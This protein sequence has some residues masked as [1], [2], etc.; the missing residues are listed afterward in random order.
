VRIR[1]SGLPIL[2]RGGHFQEPISVD[3]TAA[4]SV[5]DGNLA[6]RLLGISAAFPWCSNF[7]LGRLQARGHL[8]FLASPV[9]RIAVAIKDKLEPR[10]QRTVWEVGA[11]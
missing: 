10:L 9:R 2:T 4:Y 11:K 1:S 7:H 6:S 5:T 8:L 3:G